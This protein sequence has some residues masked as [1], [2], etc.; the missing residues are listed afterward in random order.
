MLKAD[1]VLKQIKTG[2]L[3][4]GRRRSTRVVG[5]M[6]LYAASRTPVCLVLMF[7]LI[8][9]SDLLAFELILFICVLKFK[10][11]DKTTPIMEPWEN[12][13]ESVYSLTLILL[14]SHSVMYRSSISQIIIRLN[15]YGP[16]GGI[17]IF[18]FAFR[19][20]QLILA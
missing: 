4:L 20:Y 12:N 10:L 5:V 6:V 9:P 13:L 8:K 11:V 1:E 18:E 17:P 19:K 7:L 3:C 2:M 14:L 16:F 15:F